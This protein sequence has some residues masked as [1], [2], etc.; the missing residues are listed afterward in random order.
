MLPLRRSTASD[1]MYS[2]ASTPLGVGKKPL[3]GTVRVEFLNPFQATDVERVAR[4][5]RDIAS[6]RISIP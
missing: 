4:T 1:W 6:G 3:E 2:P 5:D